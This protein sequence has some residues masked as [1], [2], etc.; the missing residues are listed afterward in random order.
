VHIDT[1]SL[2][3][4]GG[5][6][7]CR[8]TDVSLGAAETPD[9]SDLMVGFH[10]SMSMTQRR[11]QKLM[12]QMGGSNKGCAGVDL[13]QHL[14]KV[15]LPFVAVDCIACV[16]T[17]LVYLQWGSKLIVTVPSISSLRVIE[18]YSSFHPFHTFQCHKEFISTIGEC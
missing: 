12:R 14:L 16:G 2:V 7:V 4:E 1:A 3:M 13:H 9:M 18:L 6:E 10:H 15:G 17:R 5:R 11:W 8:G